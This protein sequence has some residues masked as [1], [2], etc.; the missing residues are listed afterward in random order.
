MSIDGYW[1]VGGSGAFALAIAS[2]LRNRFV[3]GSDR[4]GNV[5]F[6]FILIR[7]EDRII[8]QRMAI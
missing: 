4:S 8:P 6:Q 5:L 3:G 1:F 2:D 7:F